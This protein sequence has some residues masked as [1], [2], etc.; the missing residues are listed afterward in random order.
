MRMIAATISKG[1]KTMLYAKVNGILNSRPTWMKI[2]GIKFLVA[3]M[4]IPREYGAGNELV[5]IRAHDAL[6]EVLESFDVGDAVTAVGHCHSSH[7]K[8]KTGDPCSGITITATAI[9]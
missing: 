3:R 8:S 9:S 4:S 7:W 1:E 2:S 5:T 6:A